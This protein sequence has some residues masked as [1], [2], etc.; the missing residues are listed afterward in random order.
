MQ[1]IETKGETLKDSNFG[2]NF[3]MIMHENWLADKEFYILFPY[4]ARHVLLFCLPSSQ[5]TIIM[6]P[7]CGSNSVQIHCKE[8]LS[9]LV[10]HV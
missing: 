1:K 8:M 10:R 2:W 4:S 3:I 9:V 6:S 7:F 5:W